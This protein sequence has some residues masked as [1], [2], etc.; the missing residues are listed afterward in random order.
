M[1][2][3]EELQALLAIRA[4]ASEWGSLGEDW[5]GDDPAAWRARLKRAGGAADQAAGALE[6]LH[7]AEA[8]LEALAPEA[9]ALGART[10]RDR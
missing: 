9:G 4:A 5:R 7:L 3:E 10:R 1:A 2:T 8:G 6:D